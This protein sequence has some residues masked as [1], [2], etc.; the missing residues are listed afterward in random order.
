MP[1]KKFF[2]EFL[3]EYL[4]LLAS[5]LTAASISFASSSG[6]A[7]YERALMFEGNLR[8]IRYIFNQEGEFTLRPDIICEVAKLVDFDVNAKGFRRTMVEVLGSDVPKSNP[9]EIYPHM[10][11]LLDN[12]YKIWT[13]LK[14]PYLREAYFHIEFCHIH[15]FEDGN[16]RVARILTAFNLYK[17]GETPFVIGPELKGAYNKLIED[18]DYDGLA[19][20]FKNLA[21][22]EDYVV[23]TLYNQHLENKKK[24]SN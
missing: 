19:D 2:F 18:R 17:E 21:K 24:K 22:K 3:D 9:R 23:M 8:A 10:Y 16:G 1:E 4:I 7:E 15:P 14:D 13:G 12:Y 11:S 5:R 6:S 20:L